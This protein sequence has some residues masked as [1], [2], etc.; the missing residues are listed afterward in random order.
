MKIMQRV[1]SL[2]PL[3]KEHKSVL[4]SCLLIRKGVDKQAPVDIITDFFLQCWNKEI[5]PHFEKEEAILIPLL[6]KYPKGK[7]LAA[8]VLRDHDLIRN[9]VIH[10]NQ[11]ALNERLIKD[12]ADQL[13]KHIRYEERIVFQEMQDFIPALELA[14]LHIVE[15]GHSS[16]CNTYPNHFW[17]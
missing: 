16:I 2:Q 11:K 3:S 6:E 8:T 12:L 15:N 10:L 5:V 1:E 17:E 4:M 14:K 9:G 13:E 7:S